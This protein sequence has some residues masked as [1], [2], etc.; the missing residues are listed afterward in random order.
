M[1][2]T[3]ESKIAT[4]S[5]IPLGPQRWKAAKAIKWVMACPQLGLYAGLG[6]GLDGSIVPV[7][8]RAQA[9]VFTGQDNEER[10][11]AFYRAVTGVHW[12]PEVL[13]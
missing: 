8:D 2:T 7:T 1:Q 5:A 11:L 13:S 12:T 6:D 10:K 4:L 3:L 9:V